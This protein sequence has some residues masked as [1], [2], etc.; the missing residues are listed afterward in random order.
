MEH[1]QLGV[2]ESAIMFALMA[3][4]EEITNPKLK[5][6]APEVTPD[7][8]R[9]LNELG[10]VESRQVGRPFVHSLTDAGW[11]WCAAE[12]GAPPPKGSQGRDKTLYAVLAGVGRYLAASDTRLYEVFGAVAE[13]EAD[14]VA[15]A[16]GLP[17][18]ARIVDAYRALARRPGAWVTIADLRQALPDVER[19]ELDT[20]LVVFQREPG[21][22]LIQQENRA[23]LTDADR[24]AAVQVGAQACHLLAIEES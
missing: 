14:E 15:A 7:R 19:S 10:L 3:H 12:L 9:K 6:I 1:V 18:R 22:S 4:G 21:V 20:E 11:A 23:L 16:G 24:A 8:R 5:L 17:L 2:A 13:P